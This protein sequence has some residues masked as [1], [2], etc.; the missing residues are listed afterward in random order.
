MNSKFLFIV[1][2]LLFLV[3]AIFSIGS[4][5]NNTISQTRTVNDHDLTAPDN[6]H[7]NIVLWGL[8]LPNNYQGTSGNHHSEEDGKSHYF[9]FNRLHKRR[10]KAVFCFLAK[11]ILLVTHLSTLFTGFIHLTH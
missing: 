6:Q 7:H 1:A 4:N 5:S 2:F 11:I 9:H 8:E 3:P 10:C